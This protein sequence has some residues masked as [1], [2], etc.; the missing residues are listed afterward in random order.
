ML[1]N[2]LILNQLNQSIMPTRFRYRLSKQKKENNLIQD[3][4]NI[5]NKKKLQNNGRTN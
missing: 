5:I 2:S 4:Q 1:I 3:L